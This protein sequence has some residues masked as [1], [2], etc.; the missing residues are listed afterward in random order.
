MILLLLISSILEVFCD[1]EQLME[2]VILGLITF[3]ST[4]L[5]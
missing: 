1:L 2:I 5:N 4:V 3:F